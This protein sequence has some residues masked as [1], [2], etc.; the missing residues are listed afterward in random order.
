MTPEPTGTSAAEPAAPQDSPAVSIKRSASGTPTRKLRKMKSKGGS[1]ARLVRARTG[2]RTTAS[3]ELVQSMKSMQSDDYD[4]ERAVYVRCVI[5]IRF[6]RV[7]D[8]CSGAQASSFWYDCA[9]SR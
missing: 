4:G 1:S 5:L 6:G 9:R 2:L 3:M 7:S 8:S